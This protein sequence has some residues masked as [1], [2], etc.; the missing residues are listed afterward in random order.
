MVR[1]NRKGDVIVPKRGKRITVQSAYRFTQGTPVVPRPTPMSVTQGI[2]VVPRPAPAS[3]VKAQVLPNKKK[4]NKAAIIGGLVGAWGV[5]SVIAN[6]VD[7]RKQ[8]ALNTAF[9]Q[10][11]Q[12]KYTEVMKL[13][14]SGNRWKS[15]LD[16]YYG[17]QF[18]DALSEEPFYDAISDIS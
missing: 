17:P 8:N 16:D 11:S 14:G 6:W 3:V 12:D 7:K 9:E 18:H 5:G 10:E 13:I 1:T 4:K 2:P 15:R